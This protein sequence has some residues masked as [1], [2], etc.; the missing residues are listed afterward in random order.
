MIIYT[1]SEKLSHF[2]NISIRMFVIK[3][4]NDLFVKI[5]TNN[6]PLLILTSDFKD[7]NKF[8]VS[9]LKRNPFYELAIINKNS[10]CNT[11]QF[12]NNDIL[13]ILTNSFSQSELE[14]VFERY[15]FR[16]NLF[17]NK[18]YSQILLKLNS[19][20]YVLTS[21]IKFI[22]AYGNYTFIFTTK[23][24][25]ME[26]TPFSEITNRLIND[27]FIQTHRSFVV[28]INSVT[29]IKQRSLRIGNDTIPISSRKKAEVISL[30][31]NQNIIL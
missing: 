21:E 15:K 14:L 8:A 4:G 26:R 25:I 10:Y 5:K 1:N 13:A 9:Y 30:F 27:I 3:D 11:L 23:E 22:R 7:L 29:Q 19:H 20:K 28:N 24:R 18:T 31:E 6:L 17:R 12:I 16:R 2:K